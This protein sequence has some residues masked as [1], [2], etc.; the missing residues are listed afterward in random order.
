MQHRGD[1]RLDDELVGHGLEAL[2][3]EL[4]RE[5]LA[6][7]DGGTGRGRRGL[8]LDEDAACLHCRL[9]PIP[10]EP[11]DSYGGD[12]AA[13]EPEAL[14]EADPRSCS[15]GGEGGGEA[16][17]AGPDDE[18]VEVGDHVDLARWLGDGRDARWRHGVTLRDRV[19][20]RQRQG[21]RCRGAVQDHREPPS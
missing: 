6:F 13:E 3:V 20:H 2:G 11:L 19:D 10:G 4:H 18:D 9:V 21:R 12:V 15:G 14:D 16:A 1:A 7:G 8:E 5:R 17:G